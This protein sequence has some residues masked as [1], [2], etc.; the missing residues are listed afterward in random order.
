MGSGLAPYHMLTPGTASN[1]Y[2][3]KRFPVGCV[4]NA[5]ESVVSPGVNCG[6]RRASEREAAANPAPIAAL[7]ASP[8]MRL[9]AVS[10]RSVVASNIER[11]TP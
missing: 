8:L 5:G 3:L 2:R 4:Y 9:N 10:G 7:S 11:T 1:D 6:A